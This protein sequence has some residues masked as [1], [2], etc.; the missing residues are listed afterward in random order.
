MVDNDVFRF[1]V[2]VYDLL[3]MQISETDEDLNKTVAS[4]LLTHPFYFT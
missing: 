3:V 2:S 1:Y 4:L